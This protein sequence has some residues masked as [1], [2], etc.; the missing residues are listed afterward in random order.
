M[1]DQTII[2]PAVAAVADHVEAILAIREQLARLDAPTGHRFPDTV[3]NVPAEVDRIIDEA[4]ILTAPSNN[5]VPIRDTP[6][7]EPPPPASPPAKPS[8]A[9]APRAA[10][11]TTSPR[12]A[13]PPPRGMATLT[14]EDRLLAAFKLLDEALN[15]NGAWHR[16]ADVRARAGLSENQARAA[17]AKLA[18]KIEDNGKG[19]NRRRYRRIIPKATTNGDTPVAKAT[20]AV[21]TGTAQ[22]RILE[23]LRYQGD[24]T[25]EELATDLGLDKAVAATALG[26]LK[27]E[28]LVASTDRR[29][30]SGW[31]WTLTN[32]AI[33]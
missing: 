32:N 12:T 3:V 31:L 19:T 30:G 4:E 26:E 22:G 23:A 5:V 11:P 33:A 8:Q 24:R 9:T 20:A 7:E 13:K 18:G 25:V 17:T 16:M 2:Y 14:N 10:A 27:A 6:A 1:T 15:E 28:E 29:R 21:T